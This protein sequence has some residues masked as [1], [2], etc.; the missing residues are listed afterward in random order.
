MFKKTIKTLYNAMI[1]ERLNGWTLKSNCYDL[2][3][4]KSLNIKIK[5]TNLPHPNIK[6]QNTNLYKQGDTLLKK[7]KRTYK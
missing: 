2:T 1:A 3:P 4:V 7:G 6:K 5:R